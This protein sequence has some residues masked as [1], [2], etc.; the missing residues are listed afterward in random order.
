MTFQIHLFFNIVH[1]IEIAESKDNGDIVTLLLS[2][3]G[4]KIVRD[5]FKK[6]KE[7]THLKIPPNIVSIEMYSFMDC[8]SL[9]D[10]KI[11][12]SV[13]TISDNAFENCS[14]LKKVTIP[15]S[16]TSI[17]SYA[18]YHCTSLK[19]IEISSIIPTF[20]ICKVLIIL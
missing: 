8:S 4:N 7:L 15:S 10:I 3:A 14:S 6:S 13:I 9:I 11:P 18:F 17:G 12:N 19:S 1:L 2:N 20:L 16:V 5:Y